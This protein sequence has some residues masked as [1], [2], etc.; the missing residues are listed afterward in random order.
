MWAALTTNIAT[1]LAQKH[2]LAETTYSELEE[3]APGSDSE[4]DTQEEDKNHTGTASLQDSYLPKKNKQNGMRTGDIFLVPGGG[5]GNWL[6]CAE[7]DAW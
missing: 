7:C 6:H 3:R 5:G 2:R 4:T 1:E